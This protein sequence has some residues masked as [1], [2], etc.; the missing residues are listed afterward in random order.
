[1]CAY[2]SGYFGLTQ[3]DINAFNSFPTVQMA[4]L[5]DADDTI[6]GLKI[7]MH[8]GASAEQV[9][10]QCDIHVMTSLNFLCTNS[11]GDIQ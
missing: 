2:G 11:N 4:P 1:M 7:G 10:F 8:S 3:V 9:A 6:D 5:Q